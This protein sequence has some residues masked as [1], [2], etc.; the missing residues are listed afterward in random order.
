MSDMYIHIKDSGG[1]GTVVADD[2]WH[3]P[4]SYLIKCETVI[5]SEEIDTLI[6]N[7]GNVRIC[8]KV[9]SIFTIDGRGDKIFDYEEIKK[10]FK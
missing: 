5:E 6:N 3:L 2:T 8:P 1:K 9:V 4:S 7:I 10:T